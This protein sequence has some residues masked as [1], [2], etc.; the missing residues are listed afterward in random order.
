MHSKKLPFILVFIAV[1]S[2]GYL[3]T[4]TSDPIL[5]NNEEIRITSKGSETLKES[6]SSTINTVGS[7]QDYSPEKISA[8]K[9]DHIILSFSAT[10]CPTCRALDTNIEENLDNIPLDT[11]IFKVDYDTN[12]ALRQK[13]GVTIQH[14]LVEI[15]RAGNII[16]KWSGSPTLNAIIAKL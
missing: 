3:T 4:R 10:W 11:E 8:S 13:Y 15:D 5:T 2:V 6:K 16:K 1:I 7:Y 9:A 14:T 12:I